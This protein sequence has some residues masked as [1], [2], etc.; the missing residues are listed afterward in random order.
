[1]MTAT[2]TAQIAGWIQPE[3]LRKPLKSILTGWFGNPNLHPQIAERK[4]GTLQGPRKTPTAVRLA[5]LFFF[6]D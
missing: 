5:N 1:M 3:P 6:A 4:C 2:A